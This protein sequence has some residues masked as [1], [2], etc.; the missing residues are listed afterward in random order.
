MSRHILIWTV[1]VVSGC[2]QSKAEL[3]PIFQFDFPA[4]WNG[5]GTN[6]IDLSSSN[7][8]TVVVS[9]SL[10]NDVPSGRGGSSI[11]MGAF[12]ADA[13]LI[14]NADIAANEGL[15]IDFWFN[16]APS[17]LSDSND[18]FIFNH[19]RWDSLRLKNG[20]LLFGS[21]NV[22]GT[23]TNDATFVELRSIIFVPVPFHEAGKSN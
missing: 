19:G 23:A 9:A 1:C 17:D 13:Y 3:I 11:D 16:P 18:H 6:I 21:G 4:S 14:M 20:E 7:D 2:F 8:A 12:R 15:T 5:T 22:S 10:T